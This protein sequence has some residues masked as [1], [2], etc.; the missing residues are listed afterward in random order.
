[1]KKLLFSLL[2]FPALSFCQAIDNNDG[3]YIFIETNKLIEKK[4]INGKVISSELSIANYDTLYFPDKSIYKNVSNI[5]VLSDIHG[6]YDLTVKL[7]K[8]NNIINSDLDWIFGKGHLVI[9]GDI[10]DRGDKVNEILWL[11]YILEIQ[12]KNKGGQIHYLL[13]NHE[14]MILYNDLRYVNNK[15]ILS[16][17]LMNLEHYELFDEQTVIG[18]WLRSKSTIVKINNIIFTHGGIS[19]EFLSYAGTD[20]DKIND[21]MRKSITDLIKL[22]KSRSNDKANGFYNIY[23]G[24]ESLIWFRGYFKDIYTNEIVSNILSKFTSD[25]IV[26]GHTTKNK[27]VNLFKGKV[28]GVDTGL[29]RGSY[30]EILLIKNGQFFSGTLNGELTKLK[31]SE[32]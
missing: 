18:R 5:A 28:I 25:H 12:A 30:G 31:W 16:A 4:I 6:Q 17:K 8:N 21:T 11:I 23:F 19:E 1:M 13:G 3:P 7:L 32:K 24:S 14:Y 27:V 15:Y 26:V 10:F 29:K 22:R 20:L 2:I 9:V